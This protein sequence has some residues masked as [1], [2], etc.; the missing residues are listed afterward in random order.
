MGRQSKE[1]IMDSSETHESLLKRIRDRRRRIESFIGSLEPTGAR[2]TNFNIVCGAVATVLTATPAIGGKPLLDALGTTD[3]NSLSWRI[4]FA[5]AA[6]FSLLSTIAANLYRS[7]DIA[8]RLGKAQACGAKLEGLE[9]LL[10]LH[11]IDLKEAATQYTQCISE[12]PFVSDT[13]GRLLKRRTSLDWA[14]GEIGEPK[15]D[16]DVEATFCC[17]GWVDGLGPG[18]HLWLAVEVEG[19]IWPKE[20]EVLVE[21]DGSWK[22]TIYEE[23][24]TPTFSLSLFVADNRAN[25]RIRAWLDKG[26]ETGRYEELRRLP[27]TRRIARVDG[28]RR[29]SVS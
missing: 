1:E 27:G 15:P 8:S 4:L 14:K 6:L 18:S 11:Q 12:I 23:G 25:K 3:P 9:T 5:I 21:K 28:L 13:T 20:R 16:Q 26:D 2:L 24:R 22:E 7:H 19:R 29:K 10:E 17:S